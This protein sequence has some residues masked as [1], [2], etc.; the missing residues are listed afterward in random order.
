MTA[1]MVGHGVPAVDEF[2]GVLRGMLQRARTK[3]KAFKDTNTV[4]PPLIKSDLT[5][6]F[7]RVDSIFSPAASPELK[8]RSQY[9][10]IETAVRDAF[11]NL[12][13]SLESIRV[14]DHTSDVP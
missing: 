7:E 8:K 6:I 1:I 10:V 13:V 4:E 11:N 3:A 14:W 9:A 2:G 5:D 12:L